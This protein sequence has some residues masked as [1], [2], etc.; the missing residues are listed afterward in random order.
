MKKMITVFLAALAAVSL[1]QGS[2]A[3]FEISVRQQKVKKLPANYMDRGDEAQ[4]SIEIINTLPATNSVQLELFIIGKHNMG[5][6]NRRN[7]INM[8]RKLVRFQAELQPLK[9]QI[10][11]ADSLIRNHEPEPNTS[12]PA[13]KYF[14]SQY[15]G[16]IVRASRGG[17]VVKVEASGA[18]MRRLA[19][20]FEIMAGLES[21]GSIPAR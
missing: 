11:T 19:D 13:D 1:A 12:Y 5:T 21:G 16:W 17:E 9:K 20:D 4:L 18:A 8:V 2:T 15:E 10:F 7:N 14:Y 3:G 6:V